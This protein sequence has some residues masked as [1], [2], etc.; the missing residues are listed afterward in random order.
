MGVVLQQVS[1][2][3]AR[4][5]AF[6]KDSAIVLRSIRQAEVF[7]RYLRSAERRVECLLL[8]AQSLHL[9]VDSL[10][11]TAS[12]IHVLER[13]S[14]YLRS[15]TLTVTTLMDYDSPPMT[16][17]HLESLTLNQRFPVAS[18]P[19][20]SALHFVRD[21][22]TQMDNK[23]L[24]EHL[25]FIVMLRSQAPFMRCITILDPQPFYLA[26][27]TFIGG[28]TRLSPDFVILEELWT[29]LKEPVQHFTLIMPHQQHAMQSASH[30]LRRLHEFT[31]ARTTKEHS[32]KIIVPVYDSTSTESQWSSSQWENM[33]LQAVLTGTGTAEVHAEHHA[34]Y[35][36]TLMTPGQRSTPYV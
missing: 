18:A 31:Q 34:S 5:T 30:Y 26:Y 9:D 19:R 11:D 8:E 4:G 14:P 17:P 12:I 2:L 13:V 28:M 20:L 25:R 15:L 36:R 10:R 27:G 33:F 35:A 16:F 32:F 3:V 1:R 22:R 24:L 6:H 23:L 7:V 21:D 29:T